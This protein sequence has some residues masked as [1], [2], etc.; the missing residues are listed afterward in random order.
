[1]NV[2]KRLLLAS[3]MALLVTPLVNAVTQ[4]VSAEWTART[5]AEI[6]ADLEINEKNETTYIIQYGDTLSAI[7]EA[8]NIDLELLGNLNDIT[9]IDLIYPETVLTTT[10]N[11]RREAETLTIETPAQ[12]N[13]ASVVAEVNLIE[14]EIA[15]DNRVIAYSGEELASVEKEV[16][17]A[18]FIAEEVAEWVSKPVVTTT[19]VSEI[20]ETTVSEWLTLETERFESS[21]TTEVPEWVASTII[22]ETPAEVASEIT[23]WVSSESTELETVSPETT[24][25]TVPVVDETTIYVEPTTEV[26]YDDPANAG[27]R[28]QTIA[29]KNEVAASFGGILGYSLYR[30]GDPG[31]HGKGLAVDFMVADSSAAGDAIAEYAISQ[32]ASGRVNY[33]IWKQ[34][35]YGGWTNGW[36]GMDDRGDRTQ[37]HYDHVHVSMN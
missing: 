3:S 33:V 8:M 24:E 23:E 32:I 12:E 17:N 10:Y 7:A 35:I 11:T 22:E 26:V 2:R 19:T 30:P 9:D 13:G 20:P 14:E 16:A 29:F 25:L 27:L 15:I 34:R 28:P 6:R 37:N 4:N 31:D 36:Q 21:S 1:M 5:V 18:T